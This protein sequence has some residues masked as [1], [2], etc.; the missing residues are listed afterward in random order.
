MTIINLIDLYEALLG[1]TYDSDSWKNPMP[2]ELIE[3]NE[4]EAD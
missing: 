4:D 3:E 2:V 1:S